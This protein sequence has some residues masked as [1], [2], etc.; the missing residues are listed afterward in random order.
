[1]SDIILNL[2]IFITVFHSLYY[3]SNNTKH[4]YKPIVS[5]I[6]SYSIT[7]TLLN[8]VPN[9]NYILET[10][11]VSLLYLMVQF[12]LVAGITR[13]VSLRIVSE[14]LINGNNDLK[15]IKS[16][17]TADDMVAH[18]LDMLQNMNLIKFSNNNTYACNRIGLILAKISKQLRTLFE[19]NQ[20]G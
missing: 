4:Y 1:M 15:K 7:I 19:I 2:I 6:V 9:L 11:I 8:V 14:C 18:R 16:I 10:S 20:G 13:S 17:Y 12:H 5:L 3:I